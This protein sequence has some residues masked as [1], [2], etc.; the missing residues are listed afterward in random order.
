MVFKKL[1]VD[2][3]GGDYAKGLELAKKYSD[4]MNRFVTGKTKLPPFTE[5]LK[6]LE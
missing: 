2:K 6:G 3:V 1:T 5:Y 4:E